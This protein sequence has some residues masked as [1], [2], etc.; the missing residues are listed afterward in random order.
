M[1]RT[2]DLPLWPDNPTSEDL[3]GFADL[4]DPIIDALGRE[5]LDPVAIGISGDWG[6][7]KTTILE[8]IKVRMPKDAVVV[9]TRPW[10]YDP[11]TD[12]KSTLIAE[13]LAKLEERATEEAGGTLG[14]DLKKRFVNLAK[15]V[16]WSKAIRLAATSALTLAPPKFEEVIDIFGKEDEPTSDPNMQ[17]FREEFRELLG[18]L[19]Y[20]SQVVVLVDDLD[21]CLPESVVG[22]L[23]AVKLFLS[24]EKMGFVIAADE[25]LVRHAIATRYE[26]A[27]QAEQM[28]L[29]YLEKIVQIPITVPALGEGDTE[30]Y[31][32]LLLL[33]DRLGDGDSVEGAKSDTEGN[34][35]KTD[36]AESRFDQIVAYCAEQRAKGVPRVLDGLPDELIPE[37]AQADRSLARQLARALA[38]P[39]N[40]NPR[41]LKRFMNA[42]WLRLDVARRRGAELDAPVVAKLLVLEQ[43]KPDQFD[44]LLKWSREGALDEHLKRLE[45][46]EGRDL[47]A[48]EEAMREW[49]LADPPLA[50]QDLGR[51]LRLAASLRSR[52]LRATGLPPELED[53]LGDLTD[54][55]SANRREA[56]RRATDLG[57][58]E[59]AQLVKEMAAMIADGRGEQDDIAESLGQLGREAVLAPQVVAAMGELDASIVEPPLIIRLAEV[60]GMK[61]QIR[62]WLDSGALDEMSAGAARNELADGEAADGDI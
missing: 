56:Q 14:S 40:G 15:R 8:I 39:L 37:D 35:N 3:L 22:T 21:R 33:H 48:T 10:E 62:T 6:S 53:L 38:D 42:Y 45:A 25:R 60:D 51:Y 47:E 27:T 1:T 54:A 23:E 16:K 28:S 55:A 5:R 7:G 59:Q 20:V 29:Q 18:Q 43:T 17:G 13:V 57:E 36:E 2:N 30:A 31:L 9:D 52:R 34:G 24:V 41:R 50:E 32:L 12:P 58:A 4:A 46:K 49:A 26:H 11:A 61:T 19:D 44:L